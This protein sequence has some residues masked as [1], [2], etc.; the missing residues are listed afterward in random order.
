MAQGASIPRSGS[1]TTTRVSAIVEIHVVEYAAHG[2][3]AARGSSISS[4]VLVWVRIRD[5]AGAEY[6]GVGEGLPSLD[7]PGTGPG[8]AWRFLEAAADALL[9]RVVD[10]TG[11]TLAVESVREVLAALDLVAAAHAPAG[12]GPGAFRGSRLGVEAALLDVAAR[13]LDRPLCALLGQR[14]STVTVPAVRVDGADPSSA[15]GE[16]IENCSSDTGVIRIEGVGEPESDAALVRDVGGR[17]RSAGLAHALHVVE[18]GRLS[19]A[20]ACVFIDLIAALIRDGSIPA[21]VVVHEPVGAESTVL[22]DLQRRADRALGGHGDLRIATT[23]S[24]PPD[25]GS[26]W[27]HRRRRGCRAISIAPHLV[28]GYMAALNLASEDAAGNDREVSLAFPTAGGD[29]AFRMHLHLGVS[30]PRLDLLSTARSGGDD[31]GIARPGPEHRADSQHLAPPSGVGLGAHVDWATL[32]PR[33]I[34]E[35]RFPAAE[36]LIVNGFAPNDY[37]AESD[38]L[39]RFGR[40]GLDS[41]ILEREALARGLRT[42]RLSRIA[43]TID[44]ASGRSVTFHRAES[45]S[46]AKSAAAISG[47]KESTRV[48]LERAGVP[49]PAGRTFGRD[50]AAE[51]Q[52]YAAEI[53]FP[54]VVKPVAGWGGRGVATNL[55]DR[56]AVA[57]AFVSAAGSAGSE[58]GLIVEKHIEGGSYRVFVLGGRVV[59]AL[60]RQGSVLYGDGRRTVAELAGIRNSFRRTNPYLLNRLVKFDDALADLLDRQGF[61]AHSIPDRDVPVHLTLH[62][63][64]GETEE[65]LERFHPSLREIAE[66]AGS[67]IPGLE[68]SGLDMIIEDPCAAI[69][70]QSA[71]IIEVNSRPTLTSA[72]FVAYGPRHPI[73]GRYLDW[74]LSGRGIDPG[75]PSDAAMTASLT[76][77]GFFRA[78]GYR[79]WITHQCRE[80]DIE[81]TVTDSGPGYFRATIGGPVDQIAII[82]SIAIV[83][84]PGAV[85]SRVSTEPIGGRF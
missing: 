42:I 75:V 21:A 64:S 3:P 2:G 48:L 1:D 68:F 70:T 62:Q 46:S 47:H 4:N 80:L 32:L 8:A 73:V 83:G 49:T 18:G 81:L 82:A 69:E 76:V 25:A 79:D 53:G 7:L 71:A 13:G 15:W 60:R 58:A 84:P 72:E 63:Q 19:D 38:G 28:G 12:V 56:A 45:T 29:I 57:E 52:E 31:Q 5:D 55:R 40:D 20:D 61:D 6:V 16:R 37:S 34:R 50:S 35:M 17:I 22:P 26:K 74:C 30:M 54:V 27:S 23:A 14:R 65:M 67:A 59:S 36:P 66:R 41:H 51:A 10:L 11:P 77:H 43:L 44:D 24:T 9:G 78:V 85:P 39:R 33:V